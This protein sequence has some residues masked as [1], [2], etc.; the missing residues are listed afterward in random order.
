MK[1]AQ[2]Q[3]GSRQEKKEGKSARAGKVGKLV[4]HQWKYMEDK[5]DDKKQDWS[6]QRWS[7]KFVNDTLVDKRMALACYTQPAERHTQRRA[8]SLMKLAKS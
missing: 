8:Q 6:E 1:T 5:E 4:R 2:L 7:H 3:R